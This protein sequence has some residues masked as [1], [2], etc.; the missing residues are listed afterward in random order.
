MIWNFSGGE[1]A[2]MFRFLP[3]VIVGQ[4][5]WRVHL[6]HH[7]TLWYIL[8]YELWIDFIYIHNVDTGRW[9]VEWKWDFWSLRQNEFDTNLR[10]TMKASSSPP[11][12]GIPVESFLSLKSSY[13]FCSAEIYC[14]CPFYFKNTFSTFGFQKLSFIHIFLYPSLL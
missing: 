3:F 4:L 6:G 8:Q 12:P 2:S 11:E 5:N 1:R 13:I 7:P 10:K 14:F 9:N